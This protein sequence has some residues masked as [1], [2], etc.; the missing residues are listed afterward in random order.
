MPPSKAIR[1]AH[2]C[3]HT[4][5][6]AETSGRTSAGVMGK[7]SGKKHGSI[8]RLAAVVLVTTTMLAA[9]GVVQG[10]GGDDKK[11]DDDEQLIH[12]QALD[13]ATESAEASRDLDE[14]TRELRK[15]PGSKG[16]ARRLR[17]TG[18]RAVALARR[19]TRYPPAQ[20]W[21]QPLV[22][23]NR[24]FA[25]TAIDLI[26]IT[27]DP[28][29]RVAERRLRRA[30]RALAR[31]LDN[32]R[33]ALR[34]IE[35]GLAAVAGAQAQINRVL[36]RLLR[37]ERSTFASF[38]AID[39]R[40][41]TVRAE[42]RAEEAAPAPT[43]AAPPPAAPAPAAPEPAPAPQGPCIGPDG[44]ARPEVDISPDEPGFQGGCA[45]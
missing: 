6:L 42:A 19:S 18:R 22:D 20:P 9:A 7:G 23:A 30:R 24:S 40:L 11:A 15:N 25:R 13:T 12:F 37:R 29:T 32:L 21:Q 26:V 17:S 10:C 34:E 28:T 38:G 43:V 1:R 31:A 45:G 8:F 44:V 33:T 36:G 39:Q 14:L 3:S 16:A 4:P 27:R 5:Q 41:N 35:T 2:R